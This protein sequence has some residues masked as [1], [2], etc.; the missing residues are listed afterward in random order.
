[1]LFLDGQHVIANTSFVGAVGRCFDEGCT[2]G[3]R[4]KLAIVTAGPTRDSTSKL[5]PPWLRFGRAA[6]L[7]PWLDGACLL[8]G[9]PVGNSHPDRTIVRCL[10]ACRGQLSA[11]PWPANL[12][13]RM[14][15]ALNDR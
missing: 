7:R 15:L 5:L 9:E 4:G 6:A 11:L 10:P 2:C 14:P 12:R 13:L 1:M 3:W 8:D